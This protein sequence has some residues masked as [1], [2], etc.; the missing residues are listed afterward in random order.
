MADDAGDDE[1]QRALGMLRTKTFEH[2][3]EVAERA[4]RHI[5]VGGALVLEQKKDERVLV[6][7]AEELGREEQVA[8]RVSQ[9]IVDELADLEAERAPVDL[10]SELG[11]EH[12]LDQRGCA[13]RIGEG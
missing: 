2:W 13:P 3:H 7:D 10:G 11:R 1:R 9:L 4:K 8:V 5:F 6:V 12:G